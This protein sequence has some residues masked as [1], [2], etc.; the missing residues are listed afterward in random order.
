MIN[1][2]DDLIASGKATRILDEW[3]NETGEIE[4]GF[5]S[6]AE[7]ADALGISVEAVEAVMH[8]LESYGAEFDDVMFSGEKLNE[9]KENLEGVREIYESM[10]E[11]VAKERLGKMLEQ[12]DAEYNGFQQDISFNKPYLHLI[13]KQM[14]TS[15]QQINNNK[16]RLRYLHH[17]PLNHLRV[18][19]RIKITVAMVFL[20]LVMLLL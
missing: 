14:R 4:W 3:G 15:I 11:G 12:W 13:K 7:A 9:Y 2:S 10:N 1:F 5:K 19:I 18:M 16:N 6:S 17:Q 8:N 20:K